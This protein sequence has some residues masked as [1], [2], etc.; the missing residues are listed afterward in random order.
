MEIASVTA[1]VIAATLSET[2]SAI[3]LSVYAFAEVNAVSDAPFL[4]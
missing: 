1:V 2:S 3:L 4:S